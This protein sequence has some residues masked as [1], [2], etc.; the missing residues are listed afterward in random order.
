M[1]LAECNN[2]QL[3]WVQGHKWIEGNETA[4][5]LAN[6][7]SLHPLAGPE[8]ACGISDNTCRAGHQGLAVQSIRLLAVHPTTKTCKELSS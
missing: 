2:V 4:N 5:Q 7:G 3:L 1:I 6:R 8:S